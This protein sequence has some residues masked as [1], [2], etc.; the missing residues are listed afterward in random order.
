MREYR[1]IGLASYCRCANPPVLSRGR[2]KLRP[3]FGGLPGARLA[4]AVLTTAKGRKDRGRER[5]GS[6]RRAVWFVALGWTCKEY[7]APA[8]VRDR[9]NRYAK[10]AR[11]K[12][13]RRPSG[14]P[15]VAA[16]GRSKSFAISRAGNC[17]GPNRVHASPTTRSSK[18]S[19]RRANGRVPVTRLLD[20]LVCGK[21][22]VSY[23]RYR[24]F[25]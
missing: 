18:S 19:W 21:R 14:W 12:N 5:K 8:V 3:W 15:V 1:Q 13:R 6:R 10:L 20:A 22:V 11:Q 16:N 24:F 2:A 4:T 7:P 9:W 17:A 25:L 23:L